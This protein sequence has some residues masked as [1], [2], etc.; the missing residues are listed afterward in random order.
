MIIASQLSALKKNRGTIL[1]KSDFFA[2]TVS[3]KIVYVAQWRRCTW[4]GNI[5]N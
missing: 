2:R 3:D 1:S 4:M 5:C